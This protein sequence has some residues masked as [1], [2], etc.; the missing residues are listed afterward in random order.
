MKFWWYYIIGVLLLFHPHLLQKLEMLKDY[1]THP[2]YEFWT[3]FNTMDF[4]DLLLHAGFPLLLF[5]IGL[6]K[7]LFPKK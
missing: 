1:F 3:I 7:Q 6:K 4:L 2:E 5:A